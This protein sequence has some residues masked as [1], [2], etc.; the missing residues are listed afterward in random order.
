MVPDLSVCMNIWWNALNVCYLTILLHFCFPVLHSS[1]ML[2]HLI[3]FSC[4]LQ[5]VKAIK[6]VIKFV[7]DK[8]LFAGSW[9]ALIWVEMHW[10]KCNCVISVCISNNSQDLTIPT[11][12]WNSQTR[13][14]I[15]FSAIYSNYSSVFS[16]A[17]DTHHC[18]LD[19][20]C[21]I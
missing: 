21:I 8:Y 11:W 9:D 12:Y 17:P 2:P 4:A 19:R 3:R 1:K 7:H 6:P 10:S 14:C 13:S 16:I 18:S 20:D 15:S 5:N